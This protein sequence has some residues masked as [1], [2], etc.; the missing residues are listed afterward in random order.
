MT[1][2]LVKR[3]GYALRDLLADQY[4]SSS[5]SEIARRQKQ[6]PVCPTSLSSNVSLY[7]DEHEELPINDDETVVITIT[8]TSSS[9]VSTDDNDEEE[10]DEEVELLLADVTPSEL[11]QAS[12]WFQPMSTPLEK[13]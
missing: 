6:L 13:R 10:E 8:T 2:L 11:A 7:H 12:S 3:V 1:A 5:K 4:K 9:G